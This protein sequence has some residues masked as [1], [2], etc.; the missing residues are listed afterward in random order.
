MRNIDTVEHYA[1]ALSI[2]RMLSE[3]KSQLLKH[4]YSVMLF[5]KFQNMKNMFF[6]DMHICNKSLQHAWECWT[7]LRIMAVT[8][9]REG[10][11]IK[12]GHRGTLTVSKVFCFL[13]LLSYVIYSFIFLG[14]GKLPPMSQI[15]FCMV[16][17]LRMVFTFFNCWEKLKGYFMMCENFHVHQ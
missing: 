13:F 17:E 3:K 15:C 8:G 12:E 16:S 5:I 1:R 2:N 7:Q 10:K 11:G 9:K 14:V 6:I 4:M